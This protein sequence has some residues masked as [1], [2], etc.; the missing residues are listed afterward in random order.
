MNGHIKSVQTLLAAGA[1]VNARDQDGRTPLQL[2]KERACVSAF[3]RVGEVVTYLEK[4]Q[5]SFYTYMEDTI[6]LI[7]HQLWEGLKAYLLLDH[8]SE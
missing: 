5:P 6:K 1:D 8:E 7:I 3:S 4:R 2:A